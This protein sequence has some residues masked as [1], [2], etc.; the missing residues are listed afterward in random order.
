MNQRLKLQAT[1]RIRA[2]LLNSSGVAAVEFAFI[3]PLLML[4]TFGTFEISRALMVHKRFQRAAAMVGDLVAREGQIG[5]TPAE[6]STILDGMLISAEHVMEPFS[7]TPLQIAITQLRASPA[8]AN[9][10]KVEWAWSYHSAAIANCGDL[11][12]MPD[13]NMISKGDA[14][15]VVE[16]T[17]T[18]TPLLANIAPGIAQSM[19]WSDTMTYSPRAPK[20]RGGGGAVNYGQTG[21]NTKCPPGSG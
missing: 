16:A 9:I 15:I 11:K 19:T 5:S 14:A 2:F 18:Y 3:A 17:Y 10:T 7:S 1:S 4:M 12:S 21:L 6:A 20:S 8:D 13:Q